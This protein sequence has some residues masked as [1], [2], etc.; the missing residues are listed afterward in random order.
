MKG[1]M[2]DF[3]T[4]FDSQTWRA[5]AVVIGTIGLVF[6]ILAAGRSVLGQDGGQ[7]MQWL[8]QVSQSPW[9]VILVGLICILSA[10]IGVPQWLLIAAMIAAFGP[11]WG[12]FYSW[13][14]SLISAS[15]DF[16]LGRWIGAERVR[17]YGGT[18]VMR[19]VDMIRRNGLF[20]SFAV[21]LVPSGPFVIINMA[22]GVSGM[23]FSHFLAGTAVGLIPKIMVIAFI[24]LGIVSDSQ[25]GHIRLGFIA[26]AVFFMLII[27]V[28][29]RKISIADKSVEKS[30]RF[31]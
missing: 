19:I 27:L 14:V 21:R 13:A 20:M 9:A 18:R 5:V 1:P 7:L 26:L 8:D 23:R 24:A 28:V 3:L 16:W 31:L 12:S 30:D 15:V 6:L 4:R 2:P 10:F 17:R 25:S 11:F 22:A 29:R